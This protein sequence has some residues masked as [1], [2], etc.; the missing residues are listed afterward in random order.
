MGHIFSEAFAIAHHNTYNYKP[1]KFFDKVYKG[2]EV[3]GKFLADHFVDLIPIN[4]LA[5]ETL[6][7]AVK[8]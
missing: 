7:A 1:K 4:A 5:R 2:N 6:V 8:D 3:I